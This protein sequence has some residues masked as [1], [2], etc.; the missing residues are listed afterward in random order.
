MTKIEINYK[1]NLVENIKTLG[2]AL[3]N[4]GNDI[5]CSSISTIIFS[6]LNGLIAKTNTIVEKNA[7]SKSNA[8][9]IVKFNYKDCEEK[10]FIIIDAITFMLLNSLK[11]LENNY[12]ENITVV[13]KWN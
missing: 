6:C 9:L 8:N 12:K 13:E 11:Q 1:N 4:P 3:F 7:M 5:V 2:H 10:D